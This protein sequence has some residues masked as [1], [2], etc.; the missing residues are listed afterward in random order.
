MSD[1]HP[2]HCIVPPYV[3]DHLAK[4]DDPKVRDLA[5]D[6]I[7][8]GAA[9][10]ATRVTLATM[11][12]WA[13]VPSPAAKKYRLVYDL[14]HRGF[15]SLPGKLVRTEG[16]KEGK[17]P[18]VN[19]AYKHSGTT[20]DFY[21][22]LFGRNSLDD[23]G[24]ALISSVHLGR[25]LNNAFWTGKQM[26]Y[27]DGDGNIF[28]RFTKSLDVVGH[29]L[30]HGVVSHTS[31]LEYRN[32]S[33]ALNEHFADVFGVLVKQWRRKQTVKQA[34]WLIGADIMGTAT[35][36]K[37]LRTFKAEKAFEN[38]P[39]LGTDAQPKHL[40]DKYTGSADYG[41]VHINSGIPNH[42]FYLA[43]MAIGGRAWER[44]GHVWYQ[45]MLKLT[46]TS[47]FVDMVS[48]SAE[49][50]ATQFGS[51]S[52]EHKAVQDAWKAVGF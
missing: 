43:A 36:A 12:A 51:G 26:C 47:G 46:V 23:R 16:G 33:G 35:Q 19:E 50:A 49:T 29:E 42:A 9:A 28:I 37:A 7:A 14:R 21:K 34:S 20:Y 10:R 30:T 32:E 41:G 48:T 2:L 17:D 1:R 24:M 3:L 52:A 8:T 13:A 4:A 5:V 11:P 38:D 27:G 40:R 15:E 45:S 44:V 39:L 6:A 31:N 18:A 25:N 22:T